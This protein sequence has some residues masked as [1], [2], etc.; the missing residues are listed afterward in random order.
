MEKKLN[1]LCSSSY[2]E[3]YY[4]VRMHENADPA[5][6]AVFPWSPF[7]LETF[8]GTP[9]KILIGLHEATKLDHK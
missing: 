4:A 7:P 3:I 8:Y 5:S 6:R 2:R 1:P 9:N